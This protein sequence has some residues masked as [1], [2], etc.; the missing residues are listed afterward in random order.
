MGFEVLQNM[1]RDPW[2]LVLLKN[3]MTELFLWLIPIQFFKSLT[4]SLLPQLQN[5][6]SSAG[7]K[8]YYYPLP[9]AESSEMK[10]WNT[11]L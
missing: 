3:K 11:K 1:Y 7:G 5:K 9:S 4:H 8:S 2:Q 6:I 10:N